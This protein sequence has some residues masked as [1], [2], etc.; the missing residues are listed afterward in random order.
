[1]RNA[2]SVC[3]LLQLRTVP[4]G[5]WMVRALTF[6]SLFPRHPCGR[7]DPGR[8][9]WRRGVPAWRLLG[10]RPRLGGQG[11]LRGDDGKG[12]SLHVPESSDQLETLGGVEQAGV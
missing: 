11:K 2:A 10:P 8:G 4:C 6:I 7:R 3:Q 9:A 12:T 1:M 5:A